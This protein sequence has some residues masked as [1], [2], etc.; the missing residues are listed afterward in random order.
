VVVRRLSREPARGTFANPRPQRRALPGC[1]MGSAPTILNNSARTIARTTDRRH[2]A[3]RPYHGFKHRA[4]GL[5]DASPSGPSAVPSRSRHPQGKSG[6]CRKRREPPKRG[7]PAGQ[8]PILDVC[9]GGG[10]RNRIG[11]RGFAV[12][13]DQ[14]HGGSGGVL[15]VALFAGQGRCSA[16]PVRSRHPPE[17]P[18]SPGNCGQSVGRTKRRLALLVGRPPRSRIEPTSGSRRFPAV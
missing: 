7:K 4:S 15:P 16:L 1:P 10:D 12:R 6:K 3:A 18:V 11:V 9:D 17:S 14:F 5:A 2:G 8:R 13:V